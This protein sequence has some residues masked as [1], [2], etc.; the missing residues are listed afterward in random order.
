[1]DR[2]SCVLLNGIVLIS[3]KTINSVLLNSIV[4]IYIDS[5]HGNAYQLDG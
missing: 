2:H 3:M 4:L 1:M 5:L